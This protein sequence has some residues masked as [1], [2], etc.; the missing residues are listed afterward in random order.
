MDEKKTFLVLVTGL[1]GSGLGTSVKILEDL[2]FY[3]IDNLPFELIVPTL[4]LLEEKGV[5][6]GRGGI[7][8]AFHI[9]S[10]D[11]ARAFGEVR[12]ELKERAR[13]EVIYLM[14]EENTLQ[15]RYNASRRKHP[16]T[17]FSRDLLESIRA[18]K[19]VLEGLRNL[20]DFVIDTTFFSP[21]D[22]AWQFEKR[23]FPGS[24][25]RKLQVA[26]T[27]FGY[28]HGVCYPL[29]SLFDVRFLT[30]PFF[31]ADL[32]EKTGL[33]D[34]VKEYLLKDEETRV[35][36]EKLVGFHQWLIPRYYREGK[37]YFRIGVGCTGGKHR[38]VFVAEQLSDAIRNF[39][40]PE[41][42]VVTYHRDVNH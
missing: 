8:F 5:Q 26:V 15:T 22:L 20:A 13:V 17:G 9:T 10:A 23:Y 24:A 3:C 42:E 37:H 33:D 2:G 4:N 14:A 16:F 34:E 6:K 30:N 25:P 31:V 18:E 32:K 27:S 28:K 7:A 38:S 36:L 29:D 11:Q 35:F 19:V 12:R 41:L 21:Q 39:S 40:G 1:S